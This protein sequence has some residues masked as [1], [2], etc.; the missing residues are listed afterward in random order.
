MAIVMLCSVNMEFCVACI[1]QK[2][3]TALK[4][5]LHT[6]FQHLGTIVIM[7]LL[8]GKQPTFSSLVSSYKYV[9]GVKA[10]ALQF[11]ESVSHQR[12]SVHCTAMAE[13]GVNSAQIL[14]SLLCVLV[15]SILS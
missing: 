15:H 4:L 3:W 1:A 5:L 13:M 14:G 9:V 6:K 12:W 8:F 10:T 7:R 2:I 11:A